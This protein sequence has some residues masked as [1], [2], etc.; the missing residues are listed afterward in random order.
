MLVLMI[1]NCGA[2]LNLKVRGDS[3]VERDAE[4]DY[5]PLIYLGAQDSTIAQNGKDAFYDR[6]LNKVVHHKPIKVGLAKSDQQLCVPSS[7]TIVTLVKSPKIQPQI[8]TMLINMLLADKNKFS[9]TIQALQDY[10]CEYLTKE[11]VQHI[12]W[13]TNSEMNH[14]CYLLTDDLE[15]QVTLKS[16]AENDMKA[17]EKVEVS[18]QLELDAKEQ[19]R[20]SFI[21]TLFNAKPQLDSSF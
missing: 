13:V 15:A 18:E 8:K 6:I 4:L 5:V 14:G 12:K 1:C 11:Q 7:E 2:D 17:H 16:S 3:L 20:R 9:T 21:K 19:P 10:L